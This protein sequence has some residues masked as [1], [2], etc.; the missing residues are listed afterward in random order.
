[1]V[2]P[3]SPVVVVVVVVTGAG[4]PPGPPGSQCSANSQQVQSRAGHSDVRDVSQPVRVGR[5]GHRHRKFHCIAREI[6]AFSTYRSYRY[7]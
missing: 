5:D 7:R 2:S 3:S 4:V 1:M 6:R